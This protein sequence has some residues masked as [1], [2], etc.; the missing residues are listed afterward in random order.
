MSEYYLISQLPSLD[1]IGDGAPLPITE[2]RFLEL[3]RR[4]LGKGAQRELSRLTLTP[5]MDPERSGSVLINAWNDGERRLRLALGKTRAE[6]A[7]KRFDHGGDTPS[8][9]LMQAV[10]T[11]VETESPLEAEKYLSELRLK[12]LESLRP[13]DQFSSEFVFYYGLKLKLYSRIRRLDPIGGSVAYKKIYSSI[14]NRNRSEVS[15]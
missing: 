4:F 5:P 8:P 3:C 10:R 2:E 1:G 9:E 13:S 14:L 6:K 15:K 12:L 11:A 7:G